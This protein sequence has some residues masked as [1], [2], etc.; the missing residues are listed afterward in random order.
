MF[1]KLVDD[2]AIAVSGPVEMPPLVL[3]HRLSL[4]ICEV[5]RAIE[6]RWQI[7]MAQQH[8]F[9]LNTFLCGGTFADHGIIVGSFIKVKS[10]AHACDDLFAKYRKH[11]ST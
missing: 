5:H 4:T 3:K 7:P 9:Y 1:R 8:L 6:M 10:Q 11:N 2:N